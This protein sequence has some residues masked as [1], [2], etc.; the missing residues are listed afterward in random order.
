MLPEL[1]RIW[2]Y[3]KKRT[4]GFF[5]IQHPWVVTKRRRS[6]SSLPQTIL[7]F[8]FWQIVW[9][10]V[11]KCSGLLS[12]QATYRNL[13]DSLINQWKTSGNS[14]TT[15]MS[16]FK[17][18]AVLAHFELTYWRESKCSGLHSCQATCGNPLDSLLTY[19]KS[20][21]SSGTTQVLNVKESTVLMHFNWGYWRN[22]NCSG[23]LLWL[24]TCGN[25][26]EFLLP[27]RKTSG[28]SGT[29]QGQSWCTLIGVVGE[30][31]SVLDS[32]HAWILVGT[33]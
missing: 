8:L 19:W 33:N 6:I 28:S 23:L 27:Q 4:A 14:R 5:R 9:T 16:I 26:F 1:R 17:E 25:P 24:P 21:G 18:T 29:T 22:P 30:N 10:K 3:L 20:S 13:F 7:Y 15:Q 11:S 32:M 12:W 31:Q 2:F